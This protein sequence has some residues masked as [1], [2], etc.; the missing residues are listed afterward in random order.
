MFTNTMLFNSACETETSRRRRLYAE[1]SHSEYIAETHTNEKEIERIAENSL[2][3]PLM[4]EAWVDGI[5][6]PS[7]L[8]HGLWNEGEIACLFGDPNIGKSLLANQIANEAAAM[9]HQVLYVDFENP[10]IHFHSRYTSKEGA[11]AGNY[12]N[13]RYVGLRFDTAHSASY[14]IEQ[15]FQAI[16]DAILVHRT[17]VVIIDDISHILPV[18]FSERSQSI[19]HQLRHLAQNWHV[20]VLVLAHTRYH[21]PDTPLSITHLAGS[22]EFSF[23]FDSIFALGKVTNELP[24]TDGEALVPTHYI[25]QFKARAAAITYD[26][27][28][29]MRL[30]L[31]KRP[32]ME[33]AFQIIDS[34]GIEA[35]LITPSHLYPDSEILTQILQLHIQG[36]SLRQIATQLSISPS[37]VFRTIS[38]QTARIERMK[39]STE[40]NS[41]S[42]TKSVSGVSGVSGVSSASPAPSPQATP[43]ED[44][45]ATPT[46]PII[47]ALKEMVAA[48][49]IPTLATPYIHANSPFKEVFQHPEIYKAHRFSFACPHYYESLIKQHYSLSQLMAK[50]SASLQVYDYDIDSESP[51]MRRGTLVYN[52][53]TRQLGILP[54][55]G[56]SM[57]PYPHV[58]PEGTTSEML[59][60]ALYAQVAQHAT[61][62]VSPDSPHSACDSTSAPQSS[63]PNPATLIPHNL[64][65]LIFPKY[66]ESGKAVLKD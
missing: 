26:E 39:S 35:Q 59:T 13:I 52:T 46:S 6:A 50:P 16:Q 8:W 11:F 48:T 18:K 19:L 34:F 45:S 51:I 17:P 61:H 55:H 10:D 24:A 9:G 33:L 49:G 44:T 30:H 25:R 60:Q 3:M 22:R 32:G 21:R 31:N 47:K 41:N 2:L 36:L 29:V 53:S 15:K 43:A 27:D 12:G 57:E 28:H 14:T 40:A 42:T 23:A 4:R 62:K 66:S 54:A 63:A 37:F 64:L 56:E 1:N 7:T 58:F 65:P 5:P 38:R 20:A